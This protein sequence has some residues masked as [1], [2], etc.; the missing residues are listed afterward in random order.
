MTSA[1][2]GRRAGCHEGTVR[3][4]C[5]CRVHGD[6]AQMAPCQRSAR[7][8]P[9][10]IGWSSWGQDSAG[11]AWR[12]RS[13]RRASRTSLC[14]TRRMT[15]AGPGAT[16][17][18]RACAVTCRRSCTRTPSGPGAGAGASRRARRS[19]PTCTDWSPSADL[20]PHLR[21]GAGVA[22]AEFDERHA[23][24]NLT[25]DDGETL[26][27]TAVVCAVGQLGRPAL[28]DLHGRDEFAGPWWHSAMLEPRRRP[29]GPARGRD[30]HRG[31]RHPVRARD[32]QG[33]RAPG[34][35]PADRPVRAAQ[36][37]PAVRGHRAGA[38]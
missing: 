21:F 12:S 38:V 13:S 3:L 29:G 2:A 23:V 35:L 10:L 17:A 20:G 28:P 37:R 15:S 11:S 14:W 5:P 32:R 34:R 9:C 6:P 18:T 24:W 19:W 16:T 22:A 27:A 36:G 25:L 26:Q 1:G 31:Q 4:C 30:R 7:E 33:R 8:C